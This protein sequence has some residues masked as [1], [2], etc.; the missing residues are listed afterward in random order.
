[1]KKLLSKILVLFGIITIAGYTDVDEL[2][3]VFDP[4]MDNDIDEID[5]AI[6]GEDLGRI[7]RV[8]NRWRRHKERVKRFR[9]RMLQSSMSKDQRFLVAKMPELPPALQKQVKDKQIKFKDT[10]IYHTTEKQTSLSSIID[11]VKSNEKVGPGYTNLLDQGI[12][13]ADLAM[14]VSAI[15][16]LKNDYQDAQGLFSAQFTPAYSSSKL[17][18]ADFELLVN[19]KV[20]FT[21]PVR[22]MNETRVIR[23]NIPSTTHGCL[24]L[25]NPILIKTDDKIQGRIKMPDGTTLSPNN[26]HFGIRFELYGATLAQK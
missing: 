24:N 4:E 11:L 13:P 6:E 26:D 3:G 1:M 2:F 12:V 15:A 8:R 7:H 17:A 20:E 22:A 21:C 23:G 10:V 25:N 18:G 16:L 19:G 9:S 14:A 5:S